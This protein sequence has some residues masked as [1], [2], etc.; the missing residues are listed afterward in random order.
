MDRPISQEVKKSRL[1]KS[2]IKWCCIGAA[3][4][5]LIFIISLFINPTISR[6]DIV[7][8]TVDQGTIATSIGCS[9]KVEPAFEQIITSPIATRILE[10][11]RQPGDSLEEG[12]PILLLDLTDAQSTVLKAEDQRRLKEIEIDRKKLDNS[13]SISDLQMNIKVKEMEVNSLKVTLENEKYLD[14]IGSGTGER[15]RE[16]E[17][18]LATEQLQLQQL[19]A[20]LKNNHKIADASIN[21]S[22]VELSMLSRDLNQVQKQMDQAKVKSPRNATLIYVNDQI[23]AQISAGE[24]IATIADLNHFKLSGEFAEGFLDRIGIGS[25]VTTK[26]GKKLFEGTII[27]I[28]P[29]SQNGMISFTVSLKDNSSPDLRAGLKAEINILSD[30]IDNAI[31]IRRFPEYKKPGKYYLFV[32]TDNSTLTR[33]TVTLGDSNWEYVEV[34]SGLK[35]GEQVVTSKMEK[36]KSEKNITVK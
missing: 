24:H 9:G 11:Y 1:R 12:T 14:S 25:K 7:L 19:H 26:I 15:V 4:A 22:K 8:T 13:T 18:K 5:I 29:N 21:S 3:I 31:R 6:N 30:V 36:Y 35:P 33:R 27:N 10:V 23:G 34:K 16:V 32:L 17:M 28:S 20:Q 2:I